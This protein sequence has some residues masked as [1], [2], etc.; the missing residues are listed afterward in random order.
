MK[1]AERVAGR[2]HATATAAVAAVVESGRG[3]CEAALLPLC[4]PESDAGIATGQEVEQVEAGGLRCR[5]CEV[6]SGL[7]FERDAQPRS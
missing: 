3:E 5:H 7:L 2:E 1:T 4:R 6:Q